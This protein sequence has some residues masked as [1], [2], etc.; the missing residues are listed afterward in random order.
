M[1]QRMETLIKQ[2]IEQCTIYRH[3]YI[4][5]ETILHT[6][7]KGSSRWNLHASQGGLFESNPLRSDGS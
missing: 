6:T 4:Y 2:K 1:K 5:V 7:L 3:I